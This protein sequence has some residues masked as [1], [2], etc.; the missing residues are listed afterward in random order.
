MPPRSNATRAPRTLSSP[1]TSPRRTSL[2]APAKAT[3]IARALA[4]TVVGQEVPRRSAVVAVVT[5]PRSRQRQIHGV[6]V[7]VGPR[8]N[9][10]GRRSGRRGASLRSSWLSV[11]TV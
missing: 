4:Q 3:Y 10:R 7:D 9:D 8:L 11:H 5:V 6:G 1:A 2:S